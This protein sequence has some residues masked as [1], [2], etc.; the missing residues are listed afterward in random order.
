M[1]N[2]R[3]KFRFS[4][5]ADKDMPIKTV[6]YTFSFIMISKATCFVDIPLTQLWLNSAP[7]IMKG[8]CVKL[9]ELIPALLRHDW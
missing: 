4:N 7:I 9:G 6:R 5:N 1:L 8:R 3:I 2:N